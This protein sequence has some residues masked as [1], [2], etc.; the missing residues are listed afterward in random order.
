MILRKQQKDC[1]NVSD[2]CR[3]ADNREYIAE[4]FNDISDSNVQC[5]IRLPTEE[6]EQCEHT[7]TYRIDHIKQTQIRIVLNPCKPV[8][9][10]FFALGLILMTVLLGLVVI[11]VLKTTWTIKDRR[12]YAKFE[13]DRKKD[14]SYNMSPIYKSPVTYYNV[15]RMGDDEMDTEVR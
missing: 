6:D 4:F 1:D 10:A 8:N 2:V 3:G 11:I 15:P 5:I 7:Y 12:E 9:V 13:E 14:Y